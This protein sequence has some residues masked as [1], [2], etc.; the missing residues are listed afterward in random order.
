[1]TFLQDDKAERGV[2]VRSTCV[3][4]ADPVHLGYIVAKLKGSAAGLSLNIPAQ[5]LLWHL[6]VLFLLFLP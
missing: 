4:Q 5:T 3:T 1:M 6:F 2:L